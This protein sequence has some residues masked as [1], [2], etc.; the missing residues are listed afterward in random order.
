MRGAS[1]RRASVGMR[2]IQEERVRMAA[3]ELVEL[4][5]AYDHELSALAQ[6]LP[7]VAPLRQAVGAALAEACFWISDRDAEQGRVSRTTH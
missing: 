3:E 5:S 6:D 7:G 4:L 1:L 2:D